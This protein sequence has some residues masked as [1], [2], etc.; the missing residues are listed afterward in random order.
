M[1][2][3]RRYSDPNHPGRQA[4][5]VRLLADTLVKCAMAGESWAFK[6]IGDRIDGKVIEESAE[7]SRVT[8]IVDRAGAVQLGSRGDMHITAEL[9]S[10]EG[11]E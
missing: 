10:P 11:E 3:K 8:V 7:N 5:A 1:A 6:E 9:P 4:Q 2:L